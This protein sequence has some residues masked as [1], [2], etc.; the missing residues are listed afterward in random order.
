M[1]DGAPGGDAQK[2]MQSQTQERKKGRSLS[3]MLNKQIEAGKEEALQV[4]ARMD[5]SKRFMD[6]GRNRSNDRRGYGQRQQYNGN[7]GYNNG[8]GYNGFNGYNGYNGNHNGRQQQPPN[9]V[10]DPSL[11]WQQQSLMAADA[12]YDTHQQP[13]QDY[14]SNG[15]GYGGQRQRYNGY[16][17]H[18]QQPYYPQQQQ[19]YPPQQRHHQQQQYQQ[20]QRPR[21][22]NQQGYNRQYNS[23]GQGYGARQP[24]KKSGREL[25]EW[26]DDLADDH[27]A[28]V[29]GAAA[30]SLNWQ[31]QALVNRDETDPFL[32]LVRGEHDLSR[33]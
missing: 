3:E 10:P 12:G 23:Q 8:P 2:G 29:Q 26:A 5:S 28:G 17:N 9:Y 11:N 24:P 20:Q 1:A 27:G 4:D 32:S 19:H 14:T 30:S 25:P 15:H 16:G 22:E 6:G 18:G 21:Y 13:R 33:E 7:R 31:Q